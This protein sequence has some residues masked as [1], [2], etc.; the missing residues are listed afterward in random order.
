MQR[1]LQITSGKRWCRRFP[2]FDSSWKEILHKIYKTTS[3][4][5][6]REFGYKAFHRILVTNKELKLFKIRNDDVRFPCKSPDSLEHTFFECPRNVPFYQ[7]ILSW[8]NT[9]NNNHINLSIDKIFLQNS[10]LLLLLIGT[11]RYQD[12][13]SYDGYRK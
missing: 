2:N 10:P 4:K 7:E 6:L 3:D 8:F 9:L 12:G 13:T 1:L 11:L 5:K